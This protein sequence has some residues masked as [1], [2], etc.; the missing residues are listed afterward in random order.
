MRFILKLVNMPDTF[1]QHIIDLLYA[2]ITRPLSPSEEN[3][4][5]AWRNE[6]PA[7]EAIYQRIIDPRQTDA[8]L[9]LRRLVNT[10]RPLSDM[11]RR[12]AA[13]LRPSLW[14][15]VRIP[16]AAAAASAAIVLA[17]TPMLRSQ[18][19]TSQ[20]VFG[21]D[22][23]TL[24]AQRADNQGPI[25]QAVATLPNG[26][27]IRLSADQRANAEAMQG[28]SRGLAQLFQ[29]ADARRLTIA[30]P[31]GGEFHVVLEDSTEVWLNADSRLVYPEQFAQNER[32]V[33]V[34]GE[35]YFKVHKNAS[36]PF[37]VTTSGQEVRV[38][39]TEFNVRSYNTDADVQTTL[40]SGSIALSKA[41]GRGGEL[42]LTPG[43]QAVF[44]KQTKTAKVRSADPDVVTSWRQG[45]FVFENQT[46]EQ[47]MTELGRWYNFQHNFAQPSLAKIE[48]KGS[49][50][51]YATLETALQDLEKSGN[52]SFQIKGRQVTI[53]RRTN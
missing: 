6:Q 41:G 30:V 7:H 33:E 19:D 8:A 25:P 51:R 35:A 10:D 21:G 26:D 17:L 31:C 12:I 3:E 15:R 28:H 4:L 14:Q 46:L 49:I 44:S 50:P 20:T 22:M 39:G 53:V 38:L 18:Y 24:E 9:R 5:T 1:D 45:R 23:G 37:Y 16:L 34:E 29:R 43:R 42:L 32:R 13:T 2:R 27:T 48:F 36:R 40:V 52:I 47:I 11:Q